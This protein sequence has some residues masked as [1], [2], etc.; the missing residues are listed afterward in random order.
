MQEELKTWLKKSRPTKAQ[1]VMEMC[2]DLCADIDNMVSATDENKM[3][4]QIL[5]PKPQGDVMK[6]NEHYRIVFGATWTSLRCTTRRGEEYY[7]Q[8]L[9]QRFSRVCPNIGPPPGT[10]CGMI[11]TYHAKH[12]Q[13]GRYEYSAVAPH[14][15]PILDSNAWHGMLWIE[16]YVDN[17]TPFPDFDKYEEVFNIPTYHS[18]RNPKKAMSEGALYTM[19]K[20]NTNDANIVKDSVTHQPRKQ[21]LSELDNKGVPSTSSSRL[22]GHKTSSKDQGSKAQQESYTTNPP[23]NA[24][25][26]AAGGDHTCPENH[27]PPRVT[28]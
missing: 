27:Q 9:I 21:T 18:L 23:I 1:L 22:S 17:K 28:V 4:C 19:F 6:L 13:V 16:V 12:N 14:I 2:V 5:D 20:A 3:M 26:A 24:M 15:N 10:L 8:K 7:G 11:I 25:V